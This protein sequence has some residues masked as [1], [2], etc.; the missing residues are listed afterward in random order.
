MASNNDGDSEDWHTATGDSSKKSVS[1]WEM[2]E[3]EEVVGGKKPP[4]VPPTNSSALAKPPLVAGNT[5]RPSS[6]TSVYIRADGKKVR[7]VKKHGRKKSATSIASSDEEETVGSRSTMGSSGSGAVYIRADG[8]KVRLVKRLSKK[9]KGEEIDRDIPVQVSITS[10]TSGDCAPTYSTSNEDE[11]GDDG[12]RHDAIESDDSLQEKSEEEMKMID[13]EGAKTLAVSNS[14]GETD[15]ELTAEVDEDEVKNN[16]LRSD[17]ADAISTQQESASKEETNV[18]KEDLVEEETSDD[19]AVLTSKETRERPPESSPA[20]SNAATSPDSGAYTH[21]DTAEKGP[22]TFLGGNEPLSESIDNYNPWLVEPNDLESKEEEKSQEEPQKEVMAEEQTLT[23]ISPVE[24]E[25]MTKVEVTNKSS[26]HEEE[27]SVEQKVDSFEEFVTQVESEELPKKEVT[28]SVEHNPTDDM[29]SPNT[30]SAVL[31]DEDRHD[32][33]LSVKKQK[34]NSFEEFVT[35]VESEERIKKEPLQDFVMV[36]EEEDVGSP[37]SANAVITYVHVTSVIRDP[38]ESFSAPPI[39]NSSGSS[40]D[41]ASSI[42]RYASESPPQEPNMMFQDGSGQV[43]RN[44]DD[45][46]PTSVSYVSEQAVLRP[47]A[48]SYGGSNLGAHLSADA[49]SPKGI[50]EEDI[51]SELE[52]GRLW[53]AAMRQA[54][55]SSRPAPSTPNRR[56]LPET[57]MER[58]RSR[59]DV[60]AFVTPRIPISPKDIYSKLSPCR[61]RFFFPVRFV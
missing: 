11:K 18:S 47:N 10:P 39:E 25:S 2:M 27:P 34:T 9:P 20:S 54:N 36:Q 12:A 60:D 13:N 22:D 28:T 17:D 4:A 32:D 8:K 30:S 53:F 46:I 58:T 55:E 56:R 5:A 48:A 15:Q 16:P 61:Y 51:A 6:E 41:R 44:A 52:G 45:P 26:V 7:R 38:A 50:E 37:Q 43:V 59:A 49:V 23:R 29:G 42:D 57:L 31:H 21:L 40:S 24:E 3:S 1:P 35:Q 14:N 19:S 33:D